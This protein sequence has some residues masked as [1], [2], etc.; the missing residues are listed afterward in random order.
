VLSLG[1]DGDDSYV[2]GTRA[3]LADDPLGSNE[4]VVYRITA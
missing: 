1:Q 2:L 4:G 3:A